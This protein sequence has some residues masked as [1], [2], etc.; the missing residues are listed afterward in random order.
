MSLSHVA[1]ELGALRLAKCTM[2]VASFLDVE[3]PQQVDVALS[4]EGPQQHR[5]E[6][7]IQ[8]HTEEGSLLFQDFNLVLLLL[9][10]SKYVRR[11]AYVFICRYRY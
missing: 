8:K 7:E 1:A 11:A 10:H 4:V 6:Q 2:L 3:Q 9:N 5:A